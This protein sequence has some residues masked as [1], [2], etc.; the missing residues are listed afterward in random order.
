MNSPGSKATGFGS[1]TGTEALR[2]NVEINLISGSGGDDVDGGTSYPLTM[3]F[4]TYGQSN[5]GVEQ[6]DRHMNS[7]WRFESKENAVNSGVMKTEVDFTM[8]NQLNVNQ[9]STYN[10]TK[11]DWEENRII[12][13]QDMTDEDEIRVN[14]L[15]M[16]ADGVET[17]VGDQLAAPTHSGVVEFDND[18]YKEADTVVITLTDADLNVNP[19]IINIYTVVT[20]SYDVAYDQVGKSGYGQNS[21]GDNNARLLDVTFD[22]ELWLKSTQ[23]TT[24]CSSTPSGGDGLGGSGFTLVET[25]K[26]TGVFTGDFQ[27]PAEYCAR[28]SGTGTVSSVMGTDIEVNYVD[29]RD[30]SGEI[31]EVGDGAGIRGNTGS[32]SLDRTVYPVPF[33]TVND[34]SN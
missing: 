27:V 9:T 1:L 22:D 25:G 4:V 32:V 16:G 33:G 26:N 10:N 18:S 6:S 2:V 8:L 19:D 20:A 21:V 29:Y 11:T 12:V 5:D 7:I 17:Q 28:S 23:G 13:H 24:T 34:F 15:D 3:D 14:Y 31:I 30:A